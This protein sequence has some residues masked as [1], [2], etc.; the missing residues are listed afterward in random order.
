MRIARVLLYY[1]LQM[2]SFFLSISLVF[3]TLIHFA[4]A[5]FSGQWGVVVGGVAG[6][7]TTTTNQPRRSH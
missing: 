6:V 4:C 7:T 3:K 2:V 1:Y 5:K